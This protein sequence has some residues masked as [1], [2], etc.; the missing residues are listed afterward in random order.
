MAAAEKLSTVLITGGTDGLGRATAVLLAENGYRVFATGRSPEKRAQL[1]A[2]ARERQ[3]PL[4]TLEM[5]VCDDSSVERAVAEVETRAGGI[6]IL[7]NNA[8]VGY[9]AVMEEIRMEDLRRQFETNFFGVVRVTQRVLPQ[10]RERRRGRIINMSSIAGKISL[11]VFGPYS[12]SKYALEGMTDALRLEV[13]PFGIHVVL[14]EP[15]YIPTG[16]QG[17]AQQL[18]SPYAGAAAASPYAGV[19]NGFQRSF[20]RNWR[21]ARDTP[22]DCA[23]VVLRAVR[24]TPPRPRYT[25]TRRAKMFSLLR[26]FLP[27]RTL[28]RGLLR[29]FGLDRP[30][31]AAARPEAQQTDGIRPGK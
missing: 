26:R 20:N 2:E 17:A 19:Y 31:E 8:G 14:I 24:E 16:F 12:G 10:M 22:L 18:S 25:V 4:E 23:R 3:L 7:I 15:G 29:L 11:P 30:A 6:D 13:Y 1:E 28:D 9:M 21:Q 5:D 27:D